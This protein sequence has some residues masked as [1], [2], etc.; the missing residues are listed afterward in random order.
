MLYLDANVLVFV[1]TDLGAKG[2][3]ARKL[4]KQILNGKISAAT[5]TLALD[6]II[7]ATKRELKSYEKAIEWCEQIMMSPIKILGVTAAD[8]NKAIG[9]MKR[10]MKPRDAIHAAT[11]L[12]NNAEGIVSDDSD[13]EHVDGLNFINLVNKN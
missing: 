12:N 6:E 13:F 2:T 7:W 9:L 3:S 8:I 10:G 11:A 5:S 1:R 4:L